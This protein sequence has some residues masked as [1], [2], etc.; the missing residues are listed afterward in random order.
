MT[1]QP[2]VIDTFMPLTDAECAKRDLLDA[3]MDE[4][5]EKT[6]KYLRAL[7]EYRDKKLW[8]G[9][10]TSFE[11]YLS[12]RRKA[13]T[14]QYAGNLIHHVQVIDALSSVPGVTVLPES[15]RQTRE[16][17]HIEDPHEM[18]AIW[19]AAQVASG[20]EQPSNTWIASAAETWQQARDKDGNVQG[21]DGKE[22]PATSGNVA[23]AAADIELE[24]VQ[25]MIDHIRANRKV[26]PV[27]VFEGFFEHSYKDEDE[28][29]TFLGRTVEQIKGLAENTRYRFVVYAIP[30]KEQVQ[31]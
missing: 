24:R 20:K 16:L 18:V 4:H 26:K 9:T 11:H 15:E 27:A 14:R 6:I 3:E 22:V 2:L 25:R 7:K 29:F 13:I 19:L 10:Y 1:N 8:K 23:K 28:D 30:E 5:E 17:K 21:K 12:Q 31:A